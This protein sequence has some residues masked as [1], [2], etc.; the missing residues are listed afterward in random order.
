MDFLRLGLPSFMGPDDV[1]MVIGASSDW[2]MTKGEMRREMVLQLLWLSQ[3]PRENNELPQFS[4][5][6]TNCEHSHTFL[7][8]FQQERL[9]I[10]DPSAHSFYILIKI[11]SKNFEVKYV[12]HHSVIYLYLYYCIIF[13]NL[14]YLFVIYVFTILWYNNLMFIIFYY[15]FVTHVFIILYFNIVL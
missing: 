8:H 13:C 3:W 4:Y 10:V 12:C 11:I 5:W 6:D 14:Y 7:L 15:L 9:M 1:Q 2:L